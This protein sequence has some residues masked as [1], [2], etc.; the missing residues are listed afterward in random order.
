MLLVG[1]DAGHLYGWTTSKTLAWD[2]D[3]FAFVLDNLR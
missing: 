2:A 3:R 1:K